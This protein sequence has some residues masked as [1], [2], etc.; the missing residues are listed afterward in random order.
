MRLSISNGIRIQK[1]IRKLRRRNL[2]KQII[3]ILNARIKQL[4]ELG[5]Y[6]EIKETPLYIQLEGMI[7]MSISLGLLVS[8]KINSNGYIEEI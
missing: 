3:K 1:Q 8:I 6:N 2:E 7:I 5:N 4:N